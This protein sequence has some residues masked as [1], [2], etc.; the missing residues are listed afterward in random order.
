MAHYAYVVICRVCG[1]IDVPR[2][3]F[4]TPY[5]SEDLI[6]FLTQQAILHEKRNPG[7]KA[8]PDTQEI[9]PQSQLRCAL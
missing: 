9:A 3:P 8:D 5:S 6:T 7:H 4:P 2:P 1:L